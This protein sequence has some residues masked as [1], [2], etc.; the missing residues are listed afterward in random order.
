MGRKKKRRQ[1]EEEAKDS[2]AREFHCNRCDLK[3]E[4][5]WEDIFM[6]QELTHGYVGFHINDTFISCPQCD[7]I[8][9][10]EEF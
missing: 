7:E 9:E 1:K 10:E 6:I 8:V 4:V 5:E 3:F 2:G